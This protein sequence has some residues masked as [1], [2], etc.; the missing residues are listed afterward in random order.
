MEN[1]YNEKLVIDEE[2]KEKKKKPFFRYILL[3][4]L[5]FFSI[6]FVTFG[7]AVGII[8]YTSV[9][10]GY[11][12]ITT[13]KVAM[14]YLEDSDGISIINA[15]PI[16]DESGKNLSDNFTDEGVYQGKNTFEF[17]V[18]AAVVGKANISYEITAIKESDSNLS[19]DDV[20]LYLA[21]DDGTV[22]GIPVM[23]PTAFSPLTET[24]E[25]GSPEGAMVLY[26]GVIQ[27][28][29][30]DNYVLKLWL[31]ED[32]VGSESSANNSFGVKV[33][34]YAKELINN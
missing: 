24:S 29:Q 3:L 33:N 21:I 22:S 8:G 12:T 30:S 14:T 2:Q 1:N 31:D 4:F 17:K 5:L 10:P 27:A 32:Y 9:D 13:G 28:S 16:S 18:S 15:I 11:N 25:V 7:M 6:T 23:E 26:S 34:V 19:N 20:K